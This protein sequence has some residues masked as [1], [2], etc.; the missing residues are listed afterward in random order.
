MRALV[1]LSILLAGSSVLPA[2]KSKKKQPKAPV[3]SPLDQYVNAAVSRGPAP[4]PASAGSLWA[5]TSRLTSLGADVRSS[6]VDDL[7][8]IVVSEQASAVA[9][10]TTKTQRQSTLSS[11]VTAA[12]GPTKAAGA[13]ANL[14]GLNTQSALNGQGATTRST[15]LSTTLSARVTQVLPNGYLVIEG[16]KEVGVNAE[17]QLVTLRG[18]VRP[19]DLA[20]N[21]VISSTQIAQM[22]LKIDGKGV[23]NDSVRRPNIVWRTLMGIL[24][25]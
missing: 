20:Y 10:G 4:T 22:E 11:S 23:V 15:T 7:I 2:A 18:V 9:Q 14:A 8:T 12:G 24:P 1:L 16:S 25:F 17:H 3:I 21:N 6:Q 19:S 5:P 13:L